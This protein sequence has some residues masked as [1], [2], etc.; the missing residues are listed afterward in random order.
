MAQT[1]KDLLHLL[2]IKQL[3]KV[4]HRYISECFLKGDFFFLM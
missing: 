2:N 3:L 1:S 4:H